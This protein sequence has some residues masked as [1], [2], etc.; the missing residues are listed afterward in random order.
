[1]KKGGENTSPLP[2]TGLVAETIYGIGDLPIDSQVVLI[3]Q[4]TDDCWTVRDLKTGKKH[5][6]NMMYACLTGK[7]IKLKQEWLK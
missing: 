7:R 2:E 6:V 1:M 5:T 4:L 3:R